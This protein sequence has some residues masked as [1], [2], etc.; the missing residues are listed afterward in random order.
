MQIPLNITKF[1]CKSIERHM[2]DLFPF[3]RKPKTNRSMLEIWFLL[4]LDCGI[5][6]CGPRRVPNLILISI[7]S[8]SSDTVSS[9][10]WKPFINL[11]NVSIF[12]LTAVAYNLPSFTAKVF[13]WYC[14]L[15]T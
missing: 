14:Q 5:F 10:N 3:V 9:K 4:S 1:Q 8:G 15:A 12:F 7:E 6:E 13:T 11:A 2:T